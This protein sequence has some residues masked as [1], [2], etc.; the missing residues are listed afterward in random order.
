MSITIT[1]A[2]GFGAT[3]D[4][5]VVIIPTQPKAFAAKEAT[6]FMVTPETLPAEISDKLYDNLAITPD[7]MKVSNWNVDMASSD[8]EVIQAYDED[9]NGRPRFNLLKRGIATMTATI[10]VLD[11]QNIMIVN[12]P[13][14]ASTLTIYTKVLETT[15]NVEIH[16]GLSEFT[17]DNVRATVGEAIE[18]TLTPQ[19]ANVDYEADKISVTVTPS[20]NMP[21][22]WTFATVAAKE[23]DNTG[24][25]WIITPK[26]VGNGIIT[27]N[28]T[29]DDA[30]TQMGSNAINVDQ[31][32][33]VKD[34][35]Q[36]ISLYQGNI[37]GK[38][39]MQIVF[40][41]KLGEIRSADAV[42]YNDAKYGYFG[43]LSQ[44]DTL[45]TYKL[46][47]KD[48]GEATAYTILDSNDISSYFENNNNTEM[49]GGPKGALSIK[50]IKGWN[51]IGNPYQYYQQLSDIF[52]NTQFTEGDQIKGKT[53][54]ATYT[55][56]AWAGELKYLTPGEGYLFYVANDG[57]IDFTREFDLK[58]Q[59]A[60]PAAPAMR[61]QAQSPWTIDDSRFADNMSMIAHVGGLTDASRL[62]LYAFVGN[63]CRG[64]GIAVGD[65]Q[66]ITIHGERGER[67]TFR[68]YDEVTDK[69]YEIEGSR[70]FAVVSGTMEAPVS[71]YAGDVTA[72][73]S[74]TADGEGI[75]NA[76][77]YNLKGQRVANVQTKKGIY[78]QGGKKVVR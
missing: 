16:D 70:A 33:T 77:V 57:K 20:V 10:T 5:K 65:R 41:Q 49:T 21:E 74:I 72:I 31:Q 78:V 64:R 44:L 25:K 66:F 45:K 1:A 22:G 40:G 3:K 7:T 18:V 67:I 26:S 51:W 43:A 73:D 38:D 42:V 68:V 29:K 50:T 47:M 61:A 19:P 8:E 30:P 71:L 58:Q 46:R 24:L 36:W 75:A 54:F 35:W 32:L 53:S 23:G 56:G 34:G 15:F 59:T 4:L 9:D 14:A 48:L 37:T 13:T 76:P 11:N 2:D 69:Y 55:N 63:E 62:T 17:F 60:A 12:D 52:G 28:Y 6:L 39:T 27:V